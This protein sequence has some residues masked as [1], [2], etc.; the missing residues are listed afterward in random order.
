MKRRSTTERTVTVSASAY[1]Q[2]LE[3]I[4]QIL[5][6]EKVKTLARK[7]LSELGLGNGSP[8]NIGTVAPKGSH[9]Q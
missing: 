7:N 3:K 8:S 6:E 9:V 4:N 5:Q 2:Q 1:T